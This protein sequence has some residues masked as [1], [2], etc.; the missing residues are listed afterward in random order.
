MTE[1]ARRLDDFTHELQRAVF[2][3][4]YA[5]TEQRRLRLLAYTLLLLKHTLRGLLFSWP[6]YALA[7]AA[8]LL[9]QQ[10]S[11]WLLALFLPALWVS[12]LILR[13]G[14]HEEYRHRVEGLLLKREA[15]RHLLFG[16]NAP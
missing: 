8:I 13:K 4:Q 2:K 1:P 14:I 3:Q 12:F 15:L 9:P 5:S 6:L 11:Y 7:L 10:H 16:G